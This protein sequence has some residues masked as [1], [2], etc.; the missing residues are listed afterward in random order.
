MA[1]PYGR[2][3]AG[4]FCLTLSITVAAAEQPAV[5]SLDASLASGV[6]QVKRGDNQKGLMTLD[7]AVRKLRDAKAPAAD[8]AV[9]HLYMGVAY[10]NMGHQQM[11]HDRFREALRLD[12]KLRLDP[13]DHSPAVMAAFEDARGGGFPKKKAAIIGGGALV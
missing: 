1:R 2:F 8:Q 6:A 5:P 13:E 10:A 9:A 11:A 3:V 12:K 4:A 7:S